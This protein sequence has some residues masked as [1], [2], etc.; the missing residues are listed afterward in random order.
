MGVQAA[1]QA[2]VH[3]TD[4]KRQHFEMGG[5]DAHRLGGQLAAVD[6]PKGPAHSGVDNVDG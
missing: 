1:G 5:I 4:H 2:G 6:S 3:R